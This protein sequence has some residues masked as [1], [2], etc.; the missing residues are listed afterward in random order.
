MNASASR[1]RSL[2]ELWHRARGVIGRSLAR[3]P[4]AVH[5]WL[6]REPIFVHEDD[7][8]DPLMHLVRSHRRRLG[9][10]GLAETSLQLARA[11]FRRELRLFT[12][13]RTEVGAVQELTLPAGLAA[14]H[15]A[16][17]MPAGKPLLVFVHGGGFV[18][19]D[20]ETHDEPCRMLCRHGDMHVLAVDYRLAPE[21]PFPAALEDSLAALAWAQANARRL[22][23]DPARVAIGGDSAGGNLA[24][25]VARLSTRAGNPPAAQLLIYPATDA[26]GDYPEPE[27]WEGFFL[28]L[29][30]IE[31]FGRHY[32]GEADL[33]RQDPRISPLLAPD[34]EGLPPAYVV[35]ASFDLLRD[36]GEAY[37]AALNAA[38]TRAELWRVPGLAH[39]FI[40]M[41][42]VSPPARQAMIELARDFGRRLGKKRGSP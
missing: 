2:G 40:H 11:R 33:D 24:A 15:Y 5:V 32:F 13:K 31:A 26:R 23:A 36:E 39:G 14:R 37:V 22:G 9:H 30:D 28:T 38:G 6:A 8:L 34:L 21:H 17:V 42:G 12:G 10:H 35:T 29:H 3:L 7:T 27:R 20:L 19:G 25:V 41:T 1:Q 16:P 4:G 18:L